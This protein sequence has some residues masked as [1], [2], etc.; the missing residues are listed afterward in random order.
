MT[1]II[2]FAGALAARIRFIAASARQRKIE[3]F[4]TSNTNAI[5]T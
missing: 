4:A 5:S 1:L 2:I 3:T